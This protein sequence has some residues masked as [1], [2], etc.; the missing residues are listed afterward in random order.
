MMLKAQTRTLEMERQTNEARMH[1]PQNRAV[2]DRSQFLNT[3]FASKSFSWTA[4]MMDLE[5]RAS[6][7]GAGDEH[8]PGRSR[9]SAT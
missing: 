8:R 3:L 5:R 9:P 6:G 7:G 4:V 2:L 1:E